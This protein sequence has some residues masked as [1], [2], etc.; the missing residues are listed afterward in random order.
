M[1]VVVNQLSVSLV[2]E[3]KNVIIMSERFVN[4]QP[5]ISSVMIYPI[6]KD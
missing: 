1:V 6:L 2:S 4:S 5:N 3:K